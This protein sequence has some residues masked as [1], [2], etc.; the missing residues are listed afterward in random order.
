M[1]PNNKTSVPDNLIKI[2]KNKGR[3]RACI[4]FSHDYSTLT[5]AKNAYDLGLIEPVFIGKKE[6]IFNQLE[7][8]EWNIE[9]FE[10][11]EKTTDE[12]AAI[13]AAELASEE[14]IKLIIKGDLHTDIL[15]KTYLK[16]E[17]KLIKNQRLSHI[18][19]ITINNRDKPIYITD[20][21]LNVLPRLE[22]KMHIL[23]NAINFAHKIGNQ[24]PSVAILSGTEDP[25]S[26]MPSSIEAEKLMIMAKKEKLDAFVQGPL[27]LDN[28]ISIEAA[29]IKKIS[30]E[31][32]GKADILLVP[33]LETGNSITK[34]MVYY[35]G[36]CAAGVII[37]G[38]VPIVVPSRA[39]NSSSKL[40]SIAAGIIAI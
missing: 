8:L 35:L 3:V 26:S 34:I 4:V 20:G 21:A 15:M 1:F 23:K 10:T 30:G 5:S 31:V 7:K 11:I 33:N 39:D 18:W 36:A 32:A 38:K 22:V 29:N 19:H 13:S 6:I 9:N 17:Y 40:A 16:K 2:S 24:K 12:E 14:E 27:A 28:A 37:G 25:I